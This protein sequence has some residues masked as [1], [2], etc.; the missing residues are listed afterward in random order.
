MTKG[1]QGRAVHSTRKSGEYLYAMGPV[2]A[3]STRLDRMAKRLSKHI[4]RMKSYKLPNASIVAA[5]ER[6]HNNLLD[7]IRRLGLVPAN[8]RPA[9]GT[10][11]GAVVEEDAQVMILKKWKSR[12]DMLDRLK[13]IKVILVRGG[14]LLCEVKIGGIQTK[15]LIPRVHV[16]EMSPPPQKKAKVKPVEIKPAETKVEA[17]PVEAEAVETKPAEEEAS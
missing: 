4:A 5:A 10:L 9:K 17:L 14:N 15:M 16:K 8:W 6:A 3:L 12:Y 13:P 2:K 7:T 1:K 11:G